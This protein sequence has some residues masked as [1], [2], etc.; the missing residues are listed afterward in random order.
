MARVTGLEPATSGV[1]G[2]H[3]NHLS[4]TRAHVDEENHI[5][6][7]TRGELSAYLGSVNGL[8]EGFLP[9]EHHRVHRF[10]VNRRTFA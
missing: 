7:S 6:A 8:D 9:N 10:G 2:R 1:T 4:Y 3:S 5:S